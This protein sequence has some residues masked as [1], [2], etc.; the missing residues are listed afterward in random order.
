MPEEQRFGE[1]G[2]Y[3]Y[4]ALTPRKIWFG[5][6]SGVQYSTGSVPGIQCKE[7]ELRETDRNQDER[8]QNDLRDRL[9]T[10]RRE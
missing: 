6:G 8:Q 4:F 7:S 5:S 2:P 10:D 1:Q 9:A 3:R